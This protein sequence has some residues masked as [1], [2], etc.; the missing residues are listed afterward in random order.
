MDGGI[1]RDWEVRD[2]RLYRQARSRF[3]LRR[4]GVDLRLA[5]L[6]LCKFCYS[7]RS[8]LA[9]AQC[10]EDPICDDYAGRR[11]VD[12]NRERELVFLK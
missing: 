8:L 5:D 6:G 1:V 11:V 10:K 9:P 7:A 2:W 4:L 12:S 3:D